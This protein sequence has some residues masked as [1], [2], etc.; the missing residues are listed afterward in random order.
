MQG[1]QRISLPGW[2]LTSWSPVTE[3]QVKGLLASSQAWS[4]VIIEKNK[5]A[6][7][8]KVRLHTCTKLII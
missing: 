4:I 1:C 6:G 2:L 7:D 8:T 5:S 3:T